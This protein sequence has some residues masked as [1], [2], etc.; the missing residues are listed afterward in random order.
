[1]KYALA[2]G[3]LALGAAIGIAALYFGQLDDSP[4]LGGIG[5]LVMIGAAVVSTR[6]VR[7]RA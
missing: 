2:A 3:V 1:M 7:R 4:G 5:L 6:I